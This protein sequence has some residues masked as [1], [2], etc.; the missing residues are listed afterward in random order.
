MGMMLFSYT[1]CSDE[2]K[3][4]GIDMYNSM[5]NN[6]AK[7]VEW[8]VNMIKSKGGEGGYVSLYKIG[9]EDYYQSSLYPG[10][11][12]E[13]HELMMKSSLNADQPPHFIFD[14]EGNLC[15]VSFYFLNPKYN[16]FYEKFQK[17]AV[18]VA[19][20]WSKQSCAKIDPNMF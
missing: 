5:P 14:S 20:L 11:S 13:W 2:D 16:E 4:C 18:F 15:L 7:E 9:D 17:E 12:N 10:P 19:K 1:S 6:P 8:I 3:N